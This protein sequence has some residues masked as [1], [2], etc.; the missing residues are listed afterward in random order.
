MLSF[1]LFFSRRLDKRNPF[2]LTRARIKS[3]VI[4]FGAICYSLVFRLVYRIPTFH[5][6]HATIWL[7]AVW[8][9]SWE[10]RFRRNRCLNRNSPK[11]KNQCSPHGRFSLCW[12]LFFFT[13]YFFHSQDKKFCLFLNNI[14]SIL[15][16][17]PFISC[18]FDS[19]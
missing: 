11:A 1:N 2:L 10:N 5:L 7:N 19:F 17:F 4:L 15:Q 9:I 16:H 13:R 18:R 6:Y 3:A 14:F 12:L 8:G